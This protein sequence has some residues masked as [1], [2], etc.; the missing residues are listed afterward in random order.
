MAAPG[1]RPAPTVLELSG[2]ISIVPGPA[3]AP[4][5]RL[6]AAAPHCAGVRFMLVQPT[7]SKP[8]VAI[9]FWYA[10]TPARMPNFSPQVLL[11]TSEPRRRPV[12]SAFE[13]STPWTE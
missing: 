9:L 2:T 4:P 13:L 8:V 5:V 3:P 1:V 7:V 11:A 12:S 6:H 10:A